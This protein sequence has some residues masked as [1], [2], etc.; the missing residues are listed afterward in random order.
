MP[1]QSVTNIAPKP[2][3][4]LPANKLRRVEFPW[5]RVV[6]TDDSELTAAALVS[7]E[8]TPTRRDRPGDRPH[9]KPKSQVSHQ[10]LYL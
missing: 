4:A 3:S 10:P 7:K 1:A 2:L 6:T 8:C 5:E 9:D